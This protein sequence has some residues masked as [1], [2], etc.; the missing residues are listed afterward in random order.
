MT[1]RLLCNVAVLVF[2]CVAAE[3]GLASA[4]AKPAV[5]PYLGTLPSGAPGAG[6]GWVATDAFPNLVFD[7]PLGVVPEPGSTRLFILGRNGTIHAVDYK[8]A[9]G[10]KVLVLD[11]ADVTQ[12]YDDCGLFS[13]A[14]HPE[15]GRPGSRNRGYFYVC[16]Q[17]SPQPFIHPERRRPPSRTPGYNRLS[18]FTLPDGFFAGARDAGAVRA[19][20]V[21]LINQFDEHVWHSIGAAAFGRDG[22]LYVSVGDEGGAHDFYNNAQRVDEGLFAGVLRIDVDQDPSRSHAIRRQPKNGGVLPPGWPES[23]SANYGIPNDNPWVD[24]SGGTLEEFWAI[25]LR[26]PYRLTYDAETDRFW[27]G[28]IGQNT[29]EEVNVI[30]RAGNYQWAYREGS[31]PAS[32]P[33]PTPLRGIDTPPLYEYD[34]RRGD[35]CVIGG[36]VYRGKRYPELVGKY[37]F[38][39]NTTNRIY[40]MSY[41]G[42]NPPSVVEL[43]Q[44]PWPPSYSGLTTLGLDHDGELYV[45]KLGAVSKVFRFERAGT[46]APEPPARLSQTRAFKDLRTLTPADGVVAYEVN[47]PLWSDGAAKKRWLALPFGYPDEPAEANAITFSAKGPWAFPAGTVFIKHFELP[48]DER[49][50]D[51]VKRLE[52]RFLVRDATGG[53]YGITYRWREDGSDADLLTGGET[54]EITVRTAAGEQRQTWAY[55]SRADCITCHN[56]NAGHV[57]GVNT[58]QLNGTSD[59][60][61]QLARFSRLGLFGN[62][63]TAEEIAR[64]DR[65]VPV[66]DP[67]APLEHRVRSYLD[68]NCS[69]CHRPG[70]V[71][72][73]FDARYDAPLARQGIVSGTLA[74]PL[75][76]ADARVVAPRQLAQSMMHVRLSS[77]DTIK[78]PSLAR[79]VVDRQAVRTLEEWIQSLAPDAGTRPEDAV[80]ELSNGDVNLQRRSLHLS[81]RAQAIR[82]GAPLTPSQQRVLRQMLRDRE[83]HLIAHVLLSAKID[84]VT[85]FGDNGL[86]GLVVTVNR[87]GPLVDPVQ[88]ERIVAYWDAKLPE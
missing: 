35:G 29:R 53:V 33:R 45:C 8:A 25:G 56:S 38:G 59:G 47:S 80:A 52:T 44:L 57:L 55:P 7:D 24:P 83:T 39:D 74:N 14:F 86:N 62:A 61:N 87:Y 12:G 13:V 68:A 32:K 41:D 67:A 77:T 60:E 34:R 36:Y 73:Y 37:I 2:A 54:E 31:L 3:L 66:T 58:R 69:Q 49:N 81:E 22:F 71:Q 18:R 20:E 70:G 42:A 27:V 85:Q 82:D 48:V 79:N 5:P 26:N 65:L 76:I 10:E 75:G 9:P 43:A 11:V 16:Y 46:A 40:A 72:A 17:Y 30:R 21:V 4:G 84:G 78:M 23:F 19:S 88:F 64:C 63:V 15:F 6:Q 1:A 50:P 28:D 51:A